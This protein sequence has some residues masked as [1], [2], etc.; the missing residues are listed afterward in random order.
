MLVSRLMPGGVLCLVLSAAVSSLLILLVGE[1]HH[2]TLTSPSSHAHTFLQAQ[3]T[4]ENVLLFFL[5]CKL[6]V[7][8]FLPSFHTHVSPP[9]P[10]P[11]LSQQTSLKHERTVFTRCRSVPAKQLLTHT[12]RERERETAGPGLLGMWCRGVERERESVCS[13]RA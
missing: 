8:V 12:H 6:K 13:V 3:C 4:T 10:P 9:P 2:L 1:L 7:V 5:F 11:P